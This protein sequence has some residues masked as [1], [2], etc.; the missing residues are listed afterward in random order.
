[1][2]RVQLELEMGKAVKCHWGRLAQA[3]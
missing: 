3:R 1:V 2:I